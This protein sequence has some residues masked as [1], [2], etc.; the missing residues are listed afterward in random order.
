MNSIVIGI[1]PDSERHGVAVYI[2]GELAELSVLSLM[3][4][5]DR[6]RGASF[7]VVFSIENVMAQ[8]FVY[9]R[10]NQQ[11]K[12]AQAKVG[13][14]IGR[15]QQA[16]VELMRMLD[17]IEAPYILH[18]PSRRNWADDKLAFEKATGWKGKSNAD[19]RSA[20]YFG[21]LL[22]EEGQHRSE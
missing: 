10:N 22:L 15:C 12:A 9:T 16:Q 18:K 5:F 8:S 7:P 6:F 13:V 3:D 2:N 1:D 11:S 14:S 21:W 20:A 4:I 17:Y 19:T